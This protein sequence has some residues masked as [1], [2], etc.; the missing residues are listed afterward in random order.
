MVNI[1]PGVV[2]HFDLDLNGIADD[3]NGSGHGRI[4]GIWRTCNADC[5]SAGNQ[6]QW[7]NRDVILSGFDSREMPA[8][9]SKWNPL[10]SLTR[11]FKGT[12]DVNG[13]R[14]LVPAAVDCDFIE[15]L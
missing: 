5:V 4:D 12:A 3:A 13:P 1:T 2:R 10:Q 8:V 15:F 9:S 14:P 7:R 11:R 6:L